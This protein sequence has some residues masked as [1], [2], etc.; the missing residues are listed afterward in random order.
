MITLSHSKVKIQENV[1]QT[2]FQIQHL[3]LVKF[4]DSVFALHSS[5]SALCSLFLLNHLKEKSTLDDLMFFYCSRHP[6]SVTNDVSD[7]V[8]N[9]TALLRPRLAYFER[10]VDE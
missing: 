4:T 7:H 2:V 10:F 3:L 6:V 5:L 1:L 8:K 9:I